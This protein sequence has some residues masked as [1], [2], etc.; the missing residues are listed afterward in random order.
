M[1]ICHIVGHDRYAA[2]RHAGDLRADGYCRG[3]GCTH[4]GGC[5][6]RVIPVVRRWRRWGWHGPWRWRHRPWRRVG[7]WLRL[8]VWARLRLR[9]RPGLWLWVRLRLRHGVRRRWM[10]ASVRHHKCTCATTSAQLPGL[11]DG[12]VQQA[13]AE[14]A[15]QQ[16]VQALHGCASRLYLLGAHCNGT[17]CAPCGGSNSKLV[18]LS[19]GF[20]CQVKSTL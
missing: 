10:S 4:H 16:P 7:M 14:Y 15:T 11:G 1:L 18:A 17:S 12:G 19:A 20:S 5:G 9:M 2:R 3:R 6:P 13:G 8:R